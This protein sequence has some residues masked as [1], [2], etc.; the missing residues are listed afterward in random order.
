[1]AWL[2]IHMW[3]LLL[4]AF[5]LGLAL[6]WWIWHRQRVVTV[7]ADTRQPS[8]NT[9]TV[10]SQ[11]AYGTPEMGVNNQSG[12]EKQTD[13]VVS[14][15]V[16]ALS[17]LSSPKAEIEPE[18]EPEPE[19]TPQSANP[20]TPAAQTG[21]AAPLLFDTP[22]EGP[23]DDLKKI[24]GIGPAIE[25]LLNSL[26]VFY[27]RQIADWDRSHVAWVDQRLQF[28]G[29]IDRE[30]WINQAQTLKAGGETEFATRYDKGET[31]SSYRNGEQKEPKD[32]GTGDS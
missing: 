21:A 14:E 17:E 30:D 13:A 4:L 7:G 19:R 5:L 31:P 24:K 8:G 20:E 9:R 10:A 23:A 6:G 22:T 18:P 25:K 15:P 29:R 11:A 2:A 26:G 1:M 28:P 32:G 16:A 27:F 12:D 3:L